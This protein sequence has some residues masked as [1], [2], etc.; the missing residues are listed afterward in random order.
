MLYFS[1]TRAI[2]LMLREEHHTDHEFWPCLYE[3]T[4]REVF[5]DH[6]EYP[7]ATCKM[8]AER[9]EHRF[10]DKESSYA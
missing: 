4:I 3:S 2:Y 9:V 7:V 5:S 6:W 8:Q 10:C 1:K